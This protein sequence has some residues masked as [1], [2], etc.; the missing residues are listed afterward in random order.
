MAVA[1][2][3]YFEAIPGTP[4]CPR[5]KNPVAYA[6]DVI[7]D[8]AADHDKAQ[9][10]YAFEYRVNELALRNHVQLQN[11]RRSKGQKGPELLESGYRA[12]YSVM[13]WEVILKMQRI[14]WRNTNYS[15]GR[16]VGALI[17]ALILGTVYFNINAH[18]TV[19]MSVKSQSLFILCTL[20][21][22]SNAQSIIPLLLRMNSTMERDQETQQYSV[23]L[24]SL[25]WTFG[26]VSCIFRHQSLPYSYFSVLHLIVNGPYSAGLTTAV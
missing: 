23:W 15:F 4:R 16:L 11:L 13:A 20:L 22:I 26:E 25:A 21:A 12:P 10:D 2:Q 19:N 5:N 3:K 1:L 7:G 24:H 14:Y 9:R 8:G 6:L 17:L 18:T